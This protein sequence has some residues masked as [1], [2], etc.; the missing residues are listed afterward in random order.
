VTHP[1]QPELHR[2]NYGEATQDAQEMRAGE[3]DNNTG[4][5]GNSGPTPGANATEDTRNSGSR[6]TVRG[7]LEED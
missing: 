1:Q 3:R 4:E 2:S 6:S 7:A 5:G